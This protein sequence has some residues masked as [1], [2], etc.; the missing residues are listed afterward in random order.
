MWTVTIRE[1][2]KTFKRKFASNDLIWLYCKCMGYN[3]RVLYMF[4]SQGR[5]ILGGHW[6]AS[7]LGSQT[8]FRYIYDFGHSVSRF[9]FT[10][11]IISIQLSRLLFV[12]KIFI[13]PSKGSYLYLRTHAI[14]RFHIRV[15]FD[16]FSGWFLMWVRKAQMSH[17]IIVK[18]FFK[19]NY[20][21]GG[22]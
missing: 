5:S 22:C 6:K 10:F 1:V 13:A 15:F 14:L 20:I 3:D 11:K 9:S 8:S 19:C 7:F 18:T 12:A 2:E 21:I 16:F 4:I 17:N